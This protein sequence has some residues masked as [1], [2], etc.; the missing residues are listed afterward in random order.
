MRVSY[1]QAYFKAT[2]KSEEIIEKLLMQNDQTSKQLLAMLRALELFEDNNKI[3]N[4]NINITVV[5]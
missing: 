5:A 3:T 2:L 4:I 1:K